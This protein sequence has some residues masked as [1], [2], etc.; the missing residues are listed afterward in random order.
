MFCPLLVKFQMD[1]WKLVR[2]DIWPKKRRIFCT[3]FA[4]FCKKNLLSCNFFY[5]LSEHIEFRCPE[6]PVQ[7]DQSP[8]REWKFGNFENVPLTTHPITL[9]THFFHHSN[10]LI[11]SIYYSGNHA[12]LFLQAICK[13]WEANEIYSHTLIRTVRNISYTIEVFLLASFS[14]QT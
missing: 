14:M 4:Y 9:H 2:L 12:V 8:V 11:E 10:N 1:S 5:E 6:L 13:Y 3:L 7:V